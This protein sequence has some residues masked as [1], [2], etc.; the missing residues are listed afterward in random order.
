MLE[1]DEVVFERECDAVIGGICDDGNFEKGFKTEGFSALPSPEKYK[2]DEAKVGMA[3]QSVH[4]VIR[5]TREHYLP[6]KACES[7][8]IED[9][10]GISDFREEEK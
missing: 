5:K 6:N 7:I 4:E 10:Y 3:I 1:S 9:G 8:V 2:L